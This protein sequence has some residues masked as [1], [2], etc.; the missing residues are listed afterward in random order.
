MWTSIG[1]ALAA[2]LGFAAAVLSLVVRV[3]G[4][5]SA[6]PAVGRPPLDRRW[7]EL[8]SAEGLSPGSTFLA[9]DNVDDST[10]AGLA[11]AWSSQGSRAHAASASAAQR[12]YELAILGAPPALV[13]SASQEALDEIRAAKTCFA[14]ARGVQP[15]CDPTDRPGDVRRR[16][17]PRARIA[18]LSVVAAEA[19]A[20]GVLAKGHS[21]RVS[22]KL[23]R[24]ATDPAI[25][26]ALEEMGVAHARHSAATW[27][28]I[29]WCVGEGGLPV[30][31]ALA[32]V[33]RRLPNKARDVPPIAVEGGWERWGIAGG[34]LEN[35]ELA[36]A[37]L[38]I[39]RRLAAT[40][41]ASAFGLGASGPS[42]A[43]SPSAS[44]RRISS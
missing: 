12:S 36:K 37:T 35:Q 25:R 39:E 8:D 15:K 38:A 44:W 4:G 2:V 30:V 29:D 23:A 24:R 18:A 7:S 40:Y 42:L 16:V 43:M 11:A 26:S 32:H 1:T 41:H 3:D 28:V 19:L 21:A 6:R 33:A 13:A 34:A 5:T 22:A 10:R 31:H 14:L 17:L 9:E 27:A 20:G